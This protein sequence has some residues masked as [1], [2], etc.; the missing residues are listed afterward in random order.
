[1]V[2]IFDE[3]RGPK[4]QSTGLVWHFP[5]K[6]VHIGNRLQLRPIEEES[7]AEVVFLSTGEINGEFAEFSDG[8]GEEVCRARFDVTANGDLQMATVFLTRDWFGSEVSM[9][10]AKLEIRKGGES[11][12]VAVTDFFSWR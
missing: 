6:N 4:G 10:D 7:P 12:Q 2:V 11:I 3:I 8:D 5:G 1:V 9:T